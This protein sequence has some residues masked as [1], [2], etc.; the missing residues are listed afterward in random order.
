VHPPG[1]VAMMKHGHRI[2]AP[3]RQG[4]ALG[5]VTALAFCLVPAASS[6]N[7]GCP[8]L[9]GPL[10]TPGLQHGV[11]WYTAGSAAQVQEAALRYVV[12]ITSKGDASDPQK[13]QIKSLNGQFRWF[14]YNSATDNYVTSTPGFGEEHAAL[15]AL[16]TQRGWNVE[17][18]YLHYYDDTRV[19]LEGDSVFI[20]G[21]G[22]GQAS[23][24]ASA[25]VPVYYRDLSRRAVN[26]STTRAAQLHK[27]VM[28]S[29]AFDT[30]FS[31]TALY[32][33]GL[34]MDN[35][36]SILFNYGTVLSGGHVR[37]VPGHY[38][39]GSLEFKAWYWYENFGPFLTALKDTLETSAGWSQDGQRKALMN[40]ISGSWTDSYVTQ[41]V[42]DILFL[43]YEYNPVRDAGGGAM[44]DE[45][46]RRDL[47]ATAAGIGSFYSAA[48][49]SS[50][51]G[52]A[53]EFTY[54]QTLLNNLSWYLVTRTEGTLFFEQGTNAPMTAG[55]DTLTWRG[56]IDVANTRLGAA[57]GEPY[58]IAQGTDPLGNPYTIKARHYSG[59][60]A[61]VRARG[62]WN[63]GI[64]PE[65]AVTVPLG[66]SLSPVDPE[67]L[68]GAAVQQ[69][70]LRNGQGALLLSQVSD[71]AA[72]ANRLT[73]KLLPP[74]PNPF[75]GSTRIQFEIA[76]SS[77]VRL[78]ILDV[79]GRQ[80]TCLYKGCAGVGSHV[81]T[82]DGCG[83][84]GSPRSAGVYLLELQ[85]PVQ[86]LT[87]KVLLLGP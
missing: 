87:R 67:G 26:F 49:T 77:P 51:P 52:H 23:T 40:N 68:T 27:E 85:T 46:H 55:W 65:T 69:I 5:A 66:A 86:R 24:P 21:W 76:V 82:W 7:S 73:C 50:V 11:I 81:A 79:R 59:G 25:R 33:D 70:T 43:E 19:V 47:L 61:L 56:C 37:E 29:L 45:A 32:P 4:R 58:T 14:V 15:A 39:V 3:A 64:E 75:R 8:L 35:A 30:P 28:V 84:G 6:P 16:A 44:V 13:A 1:A 17:D 22:A 2:S 60:L 80:V 71:V 54:A 83:A 34:F 62:S 48:M 20:P 42:A 10:A 53:G 78:R 36:T 12:G 41:D 57:T 63:Q 38:P 31:G 18:A 9:H 72:G 74:E